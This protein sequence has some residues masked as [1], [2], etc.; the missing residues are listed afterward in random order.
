M[1]RIWWHLLNDNV[2]LMLT[3]LGQVADNDPL[4]TPSTPTNWLTAPDYTNVSNMPWY[5]LVNWWAD[6]F[7]IQRSTLWFLSAMFISMAV[8]ILAY[9]KGGHK[10]LL[11]DGAVM[12]C[13]GLF[14]AMQLTPYWLLM[15]FLIFAITAV[16]IGER[17]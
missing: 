12:V 7:G 11:A 2:T 5:G 10:I 17:I 16:A 3:T 9:W 13:I 14:A 15:P 8:G 6:S 4:P 1:G